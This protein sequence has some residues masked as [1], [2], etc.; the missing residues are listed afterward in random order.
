MGRACITSLHLHHHFEPQSDPSAEGGA[1]LHHDLAFSVQCRANHLYALLPSS[2]LRDNNLDSLWLRSKV[3]RVS[4]PT[5][6]LG[7]RLAAS[8]RLGV[9][10]SSQEPHGSFA[11]VSDPISQFLI[12]FV[13]AVLVS[14]Y[15]ALVFAFVSSTPNSVEM[16][17]IEGGKVMWGNL[18]KVG[19]KSS[20]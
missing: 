5:S 9:E 13:L 1:S 16:S 10:G 8:H 18:Y 3:G 14:C 11:A 20:T 4:G 7:S 2:F 19:R 15:V 17:M 12:V 6:G